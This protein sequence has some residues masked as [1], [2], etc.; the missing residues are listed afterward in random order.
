M[1][2]TKNSFYVY[3]I[4]H[5]DN[6]QCTSKEEFEEDLKRFFYIKKLFGRYEKNKDL[7][8]RLI[9]NHMIVLYNVFGT[10]CTNMLFMK[11]K[12]YSS[13]IKPFIIQLGYLKPGQLIE[14][15]DK[16]IYESDIGMDM[17]IVERLR[18]I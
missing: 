16:K 12:Q 10:Y 4:H 15:D 17:L 7:Q 13:Y 6:P 5:Y 2:L 1:R 9:L 3:A 11:M 8:E 18:G 14:Y